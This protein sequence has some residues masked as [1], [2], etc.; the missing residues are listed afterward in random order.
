MKPL[1]HQPVTGFPEKS[2]ITHF[3]SVNIRLLMFRSYEDKYW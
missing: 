3:I 2:K 1:E